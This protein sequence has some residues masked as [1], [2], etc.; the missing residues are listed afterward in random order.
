MSDLGKNIYDLLNNAEMDLRE[1][2]VQDLSFEEKSMYKQRI[3]EKINKIGK[4]SKKRKITKIMK[5]AAGF[6]AAIA[7]TF[8]IIGVVNPSLAKD[9][10]NAVFSTIIE[11]A[12]KDLVLYNEDICAKIGEVAVPIEEELKKR[13]NETDYVTSSECNGITVSVSDVY[14]DGYILYYTLKLDVDNEVLGNAEELF[15]SSLNE[16]GMAT[17]EIEGIDLFEYGL[18]ESVSSFNKSEKGTY[19]SMNEVYFLQGLPDNNETIVANFHMSGVNAYDWSTYLMAEDSDISANVDGEWNLRFPITVDSSCNEI[20]EINKE[21][22]GITLRNLVKT[23]VAIM[24][25]VAVDLSVDDY[26]NPY[27][28]VAVGLLDSNGNYLPHVITDVKYDAGDHVY[29]DMCMY[30]DQTDLNVSIEMPGTG[31]NPPPTIPLT[32]FDVKLTSSFSYKMNNHKAVKMK[33]AGV[34]S[35]RYEENIDASEDEWI[36]RLSINVYEDMSEE[37][38]LS[39]LE[40]EEFVLNA[41]FVKTEND[42]IKYLGEKDR[43][44]IGYAAFYKGTTDEV[45]GKYKYKNHKKVDYTEDDEKY[46]LNPLW[47]R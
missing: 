23:R 3:L 27:G 14:C 32:E 20:I 41:D 19:V 26:F 15:P 7:L 39:I 28:H 30:D 42:E 16:G 8:G 4:S 44:F 18:G 2:E 24:T 43:D 12:K 25:E 6:A 31:E 11:Y 1:Y 5:T 38:M 37:D 35:Y 29:Y 34:W 17:M 46:F 9:I 13:P 45:I 10:Y 21:D 40:Y 33:D 36:C 22:K 47:K